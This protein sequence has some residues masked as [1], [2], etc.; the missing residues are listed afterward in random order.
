MNEQKNTEPF[1][2]K[3]VEKILMQFVADVAGSQRQIDIDLINSLQVR[4]DF[5]EC[6]RTERKNFLKN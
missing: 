1:N 4:S 2:I 6:I 3:F 5:L